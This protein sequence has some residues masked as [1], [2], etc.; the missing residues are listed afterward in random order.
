MNTQDL[1]KEFRLKSKKALS[2]I[3]SIVENNELE[4]VKWMEHIYSFTGKSQIWGITGPPGAGKSSLTNGLIT[5]LREQNKTVA[6][7]SAG[8]YVLSKRPPSF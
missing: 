6:G 8:V 1:L 2:R 3:L 5:K 4:K 7:S